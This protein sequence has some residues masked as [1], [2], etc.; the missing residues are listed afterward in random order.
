MASMAAILQSRGHQC[1]FFFFRHGPME[2]HLPAN[3]PAHFGDLADCLRL[4]SSRGFDLVH[5]NSMDWHLGISAVRGVGAR[6]VATAHGMVV[7]GWTSANCDM[8]VTCASWLAGEY[9]VVTDL[10]PQVVLNGI[11]LNVFKTGDRDE[12][13]GAPIVAWVGRG[14]DPV[15]GLSRLAAMAPALRRAGL[16]LWLAEPYGPDE[17]ENA[18]PGGKDALLPLAEVWRAVPRDEMPSFYQEVAAS[19]GCMM[20]TS[21]TEGLPMSLLEAQACGCPVIGPDVRGVNECVDPASGGILYPPDSPPELLAST[22]IETL[23]DAKGARRR[24]AASARF[25]QENFSL[26]RMADDYLRV[27]EVALG[28]KPNGW[29]GLAARLQLSPVFNWKNYVAHRWGP[30]RCQ[31]EASRQLAEL[32]DWTLASVAA[33]AALLMSPTIFVRPERLAHLLKTLSRGGDWKLEP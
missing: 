8:L 5:T 4:V 19:A 18:V 12:P 2:Q 30:G 6:L 1:E 3:C 25:V 33:R 32:G 29:S 13:N 16:R 28:A 21:Q 31:Y 11:D 14:I 20:S 10:T 17:V 24:G 15:K 27:Y 7:P 26:E 23:R 22:V 9:K